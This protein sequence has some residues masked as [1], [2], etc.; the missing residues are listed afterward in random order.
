MEFQAMA[1]TSKNGGQRTNTTSGSGRKERSP[2]SPGHKGSR[3]EPSHLSNQASEERDKKLVR[4]EKTVAK[5][6]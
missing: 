1:G 3:V 2:T 4:D 5:R 6:K